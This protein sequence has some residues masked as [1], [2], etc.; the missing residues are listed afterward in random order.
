VAEVAQSATVMW[1]SPCHIIKNVGSGTFFKHFCF[2]RNVFQT[3]FLQDE[4]QNGSKL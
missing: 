1:Q 4:N 2:Y 3:F